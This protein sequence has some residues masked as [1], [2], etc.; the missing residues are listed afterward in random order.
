MR[1]GPIFG[2]KQPLVESKT[3]RPVTKTNKDETMKALKKERQ[4]LEDTADQLITAALGAGADKA[5]VCATYSQN[6]KIT[7]EKQDYHLASADDGYQFGIRVLKGP[8]QGFSSCNTIDPKEIR[9][10]ARKAVEISGFSPE[11]ENQTIEPSKNLSSDAPTELW[12]DSLHK[13]SLKSQKDWTQLMVKETFK[14]KRIRLNEGAVEIGSSMF[15]I[16]NSMGTHKLEQETVASWTVMGMATEGE[17]ITSFD[18]FQELSRH[19]AQV[20]ERIVMSTRSF[21]D[22]LLAN[23]NQG[24]AQTYK[25]KVIFTPRA[26]CEVLLSAITYHL[27]GSNLAEGTTRWQ[28][29]DIGN[30]VLSPLLNMHDDPWLTDR[31]GCTLF[32]R[33]G[34]PTRKLNLIEQ[35]KLAAYTMDHYCAKALGKVST[36]HAGGGPSSTPSVG[37]HSL[38]VNGGQTPKDK[39]YSDTASEQDHFLVVHRFSGQ[40]DPVSGDF[41]G[42]AKGGEWWIGNK[43]SHFV[44]ETMISGNLFDALGPALTAVSAETL[45]VDSHVEVPW[46]LV[47]G[48]SVTSGK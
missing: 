32:D 33:E 2:A 30:T 31:A 46:L 20:P 4:I 24:P 45:V 38:V 13:L 11:N 43:Q 15:L 9:E 29:S 40:T 48:V 16:L 35:G 47:D 18:Y 21:C 34:T 17:V 12:D 23:L 6:S 22:M 36:G 8:H 5:E 14:D 44:Q 42:V 39:M 3:K 19:A 28:L 37:T 7:L 26:A 10:V 27:N 1:A 25:G 41:S